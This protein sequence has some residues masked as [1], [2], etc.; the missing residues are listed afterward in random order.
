METRSQ[1]M[2]KEA[3][4]RESEGSFGSRITVLEEKLEEQAEKLNNKL[5]HHIVEIFEA[6][7]LISYP[8]GNASVN[9]ERRV[10]HSSPASHSYES[11]KGRS[12]TAHNYSGRTRLAKLDFPR[13]DGDNM[14]EWLSKVE[15]FFSIDVTPDDL[16]VGLASMHFDGLASAW[17]QS[18]MQSDEGP[19]LL[20][21]WITYRMLLVE[22][23]EDVL[24]DP[25]AELKELKETD[26]IVEYHG[27]FEL[28]RVRVKM[29]EAYLVSA[30]LAGLR[31][32]TQM[33][34]RMFQPQTVRQCLMLGRLY[35]KAHPKKPFQSSWSQSKPVNNSKGI[36]PFKKE[37]V[38]T[39]VQ[40]EKKNNLPLK[41]LS[42]EEM[43]K[44]RAAGLCYFCDEKYTP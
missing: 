32:D 42:Q 6:I 36:L 34:V 18:L 25:I 39:A 19:E 24:D 8:K 26:G 43:S 35:E 41:P 2:M 20:Y 31:T 16:K 5:D 29:S 7:R 22:R 23:F 13:F 37:G 21:D 3:T 15:Q 9:D 38:N 12:G 1:T 33:H 17:H 30:Y 28:I 27:K 40:K 11:G 14:K 4:I 44:R 10:D